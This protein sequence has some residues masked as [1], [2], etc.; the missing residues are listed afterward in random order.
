I[1]GHSLG[2]AMAASYLA[3]T[4]EKYDGLILLAAYTTADLW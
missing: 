4:E 1:G 3:E 2:G